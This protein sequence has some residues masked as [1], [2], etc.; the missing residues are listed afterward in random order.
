MQEASSYASHAVVS[1]ANRFFC[2]IHQYQSWKA[3]MSLG[4]VAC[5]DGLNG[6]LSKLPPFEVTLSPRLGVRL[7]RASSACKGLHVSDRRCESDSA[8]DC[9]PE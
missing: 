8:G 7:A 2:V 3:Y 1:A 9:V 6:H 4:S 5:L